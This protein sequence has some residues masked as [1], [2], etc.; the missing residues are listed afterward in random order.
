M[1]QVRAVALEK[2]TRFL[3]HP[4]NP[5]HAGIAH[6][7]RRAMSMAGKKIDRAADTNTHWNA[8]TL[9]M[10]VDPL[11]LLRTTEADEKEIGSGRLNAVNNVV[12]IHFRQRL[13]GRRMLADN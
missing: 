3:R 6:P 9:V 1:P 10:H 13:E 2:A 5:F 7:H 11:F 8:E 12:V 4:I